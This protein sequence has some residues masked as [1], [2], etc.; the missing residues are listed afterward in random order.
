MKGCVYAPGMLAIRSLPG[1]WRA[2]YEFPGRLLL[3]AT[4]PDH[5]WPYRKVEVWQCRQLAAQVCYTGDT[6]II[7]LVRFLRHDQSPAQDAEDS[8]MFSNK[9]A[10]HGH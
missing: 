4:S 5:V 9:T 8:E 1:S 6:Q 3:G 2:R 7:R 10:C